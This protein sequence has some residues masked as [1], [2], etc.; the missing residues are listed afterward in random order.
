MDRVFFFDSPPNI[1]YYMVHAYGPKHVKT[2]VPDGILSHSLYSW[3][4]LPPNMVNPCKS[5]GYEPSPYGCFPTFSINRGT[6][7]GWSIARMVVWQH[8]TAAAVPMVPKGSRSD[9]TACFVHISREAG[10][11]RPQPPAMDAS[12]AADKH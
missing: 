3:M 1:H 9:Q 4:V 11:V 6:Q 8:G 12:Q 2:L 5:I 7:N 10:G